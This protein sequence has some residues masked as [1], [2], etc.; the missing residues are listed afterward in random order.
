MFLIV[1]VEQRVRART[2]IFKTY[3]S[4][5]YVFGL[6]F[7]TFTLRS[8]DFGYCL[9]VSTGKKKESI[10]VAVTAQFAKNPLFLLFMT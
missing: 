5:H 3:F 7:F 6:F 1:K 10:C 2:E 4:M 9:C 8:K